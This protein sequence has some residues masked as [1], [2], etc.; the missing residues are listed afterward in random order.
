MRSI[1]SLTYSA[2]SVQPAKTITRNKKGGIPERSNIFAFIGGAEGMCTI[3][4]HK[5][6][7]RACGRHA[8]ACGLDLPTKRFDAKL[9]YAD[10]QALENVLADRDRP[11]RTRRA[12]GRPKR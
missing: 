9:W 7:M 5:Q 8:Q 10:Y 11:A 6:A 1:A 3:F 2:G 12:A 4:N